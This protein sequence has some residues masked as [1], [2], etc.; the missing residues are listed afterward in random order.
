VFRVPAVAVARPAPPPD[1]LDPQAVASFQQ[2]V[3][4]L[5]AKRYR[6]AA[7][8][9]RS[10]LERFPGER[11]LLERSRLYLQLAE[12]E[13]NREEANPRTIEERL[14]AATAALNTDQD[15]EA[16]RLV[17][18]VLGDDPKHDLALYLMAA[19]E[20][21]RGD[22]DAA[23]TFLTRA[24]SVSPEVRAQARHDR[25]FESL[26]HSDRFHQLVDPQ[27]ANGSSRRARRAR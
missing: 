3:E 4:A 14:T 1:L 26:R 23:I 18:A 11:P 12:R 9:F 19:I 15:A 20:A 21:R 7:D 17:R 25:D 10:L 6:A 2:A 8:Q 22:S 24:I 16:E 5:Y 13:M 27:N